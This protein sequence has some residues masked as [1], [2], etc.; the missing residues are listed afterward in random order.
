MRKVSAI[1]RLPAEPAK[2]HR[3][4][5]SETLTDAAQGRF[6]KSSNRCCRVSELIDLRGEQIDFNGAMLHVSRLKQG[7]AA[8]HPLTGRELRVLRK[9][10]RDQKPK[11]AFVFT[12]ERGA[13]FTNRGFSNAC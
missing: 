7:R 8:T 4:S 9:L 5:R 13:P 12:S 11:S 2:R 3:R 1:Y 10:R 6:R